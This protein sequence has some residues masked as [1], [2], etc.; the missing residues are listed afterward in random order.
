M[1]SEK[2]EKDAMNRREADALN[3]MVINTLV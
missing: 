3:R 1:N 2:K